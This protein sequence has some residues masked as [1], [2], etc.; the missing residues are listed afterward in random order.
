M[1]NV[2]ISGAWYSGRSTTSKLDNLLVRPSDYAAFT[3]P[4]PLD[5][6]DILTI[7]NLARAKQGQVNNLDT[8]SADNRRF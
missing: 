3:T 7:F 1:N 8:N 4:N 6:T 5:P 2:S